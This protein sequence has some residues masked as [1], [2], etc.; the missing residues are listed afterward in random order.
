V[1]VLTRAARADL[2]GDAFNESVL[3]RP[4]LSMSEGLSRF[5]N[6]GVDGV[7]NAVGATAKFTS[8]RLRRLQ[9]GYIRS[10]AMFVAVSMVVLMGVLVLVLQA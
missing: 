8:W 7:V 4:G 9:T 6:H 3:M 1:S 10:Y 2:Y 5:D